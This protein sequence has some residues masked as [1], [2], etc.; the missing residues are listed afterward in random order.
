MA[1]ACG[2]QAM[3]LTEHARFVHQRADVVIPIW[4][5]NFFIV[6][7]LVPPFWE[8]N[9]AIAQPLSNSNPMPPWSQHGPCPAGSVSN[10]IKRFNKRYI[11]SYLHVPYHL[12]L[13]DL[14]CQ[15]PSSL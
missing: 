7:C 5:I 3:H 8:S 13:C 10:I 4:C 9:W 1:A 12:L 15:S 14:T 2:A 11:P 6:S